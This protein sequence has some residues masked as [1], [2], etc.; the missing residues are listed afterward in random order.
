MKH[1]NNLSRIKDRFFILWQYKFF[2]CAVLIHLAY[3]V[4]SLVLVLTI[5]RGQ[6]D[7]LIY[8]TAGGV[9]YNNPNNLY[10]QDQYIWDYRYLPLSAT[11]FIPFYLLGFDLG[12]IL[13][14]TLNLILNLMICKL[15]Y[16]IIILVRG[17]DHEKDDR[18]IILYMSVYLVAAPQMFNYILGQINLYIT[19]FMLVAL[20]IFL[21]HET[22]K[23]QFIGSMILGVSIILKPTALLLIPFLLVFNYDVIQK[24]LDFDLMKSFARIAGVLFPISLNI[25]IF[26][27]YPKL[28]DGFIETNFTGGNPLTLNFSFSITKIVLNFCY[29]YNVPFNQMYVFLIIFGILGF[30]GYTFYLF[31]KYHKR[32]AIIYGFTFGLVITLLVYFDS[33]DHHLLNLIPLLM[34]IIFNLPR[35]SELSDKYFKKGFFFFSFFD[36]AFMGLWFITI[37]FWFPYNFASTIFLILVFY[38]L[39]KHSLSAGDNSNI[40]NFNKGARDDGF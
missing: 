17:Q 9:F 39:S 1:K 27:L 36:L 21:M 18:R 32:D 37:I 26:I 14:H 10:V 8:Y 31:G 35:H 12:F 25:I 29:M 22:L 11:F 3:F 4:I 13:F 33:W 6:N 5:L 24:K 34:I 40:N 7:F 16:K 23:W 38:G 28:W 20:Y 19:F 2:R 30:L 15:L